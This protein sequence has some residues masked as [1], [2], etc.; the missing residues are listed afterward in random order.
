MLQHSQ[1]L[2]QVTAQH[3]FK[4][5]HPP[6]LLSSSVTSTSLDPFREDHEANPPADCPQREGPGRPFDPCRPEGGGGAF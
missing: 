1:K 2:A 4:N 3:F 6:P 5:Q